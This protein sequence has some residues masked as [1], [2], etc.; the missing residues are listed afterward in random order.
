M[1]V[2]LAVTRARCVRVRSSTALIDSS[3]RIG[4]PGILCEQAEKKRVVYTYMRT[5]TK[6]YLY[7]SSTDQV[8]GRRRAC[9]ELGFHFLPPSLSTEIT[10]PCRQPEHNGSDEEAWLYLGFPMVCSNGAHVV[11]CSGP[12]LWRN[13]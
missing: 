1:D 4:I 13:S 10:R 11:V 12:A 9:R 7:H 2:A 8:P 6:G 3:T 5:S